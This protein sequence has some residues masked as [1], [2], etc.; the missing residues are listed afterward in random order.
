[1]KWAIL[2]DVHGNLEALQAVLQETEREG[3]NRLVCLGDAVGYGADPNACVLLLRERT[4]LFVAGNHDWGAVGLTDVSF[5]NP[6]AKAAIAWTARVLT[7]GS[8]SFLQTLPLVRELNEFTFFHASPLAPEEWNYILSIPEAKKE[9]RGL[10]G[11]LAFFGH[12]HLPLVW[13]Q[14]PDGEVSVLEKQDVMLQEG[15][16]YMINVGSVGQP[17]DGDPLAAY[18]LY[19]DEAKEV[20]LRRVSYDI[21]RAQGKILQ[22]GLPSSLAQRLAQ[23][24]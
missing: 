24:W 8:R 4:D 14:Q 11:D 20:L 12:S 15:R 5:F 17:R 10:A 19:D 22:A 2:S 21:P 7:R 23:G 3:V 13:V 1:M 18:G 9:F 16:R 6:L